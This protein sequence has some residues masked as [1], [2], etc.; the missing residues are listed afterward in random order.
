MFHGL[1]FLN[2]SMM[3]C[4][5]N[6]W[7]LVMSLQNFLYKIDIKACCV[8]MQYFLAV[9]AMFFAGW[10]LNLLARGIVFDL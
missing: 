7:M 10:V 8:F 4:S 6:F 5:K 1:L 9:F 3:K 2:I